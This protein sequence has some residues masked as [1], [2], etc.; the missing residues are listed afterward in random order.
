PKRCV[1]PTRST[2]PHSAKPCSAAI[3]P[4]GAGAA[5][6]ALSAVVE[7]APHPFLGWLNA[8]EWLQVARIHTMHH[9]HIIDELLGA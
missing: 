5:A 7:R 2:S 3:R 9:L 4:R 1:R 8:T 6:S